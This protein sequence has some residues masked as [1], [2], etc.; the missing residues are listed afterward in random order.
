MFPIAYCGGPEVYSINLT[1]PHF[2]SPSVKTNRGV[3]F[4]IVAE[5]GALV[6]NIRLS[7][8]FIESDDSLK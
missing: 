1:F 3:K 2:T 6:D 5:V 4:D 8:F 7:I